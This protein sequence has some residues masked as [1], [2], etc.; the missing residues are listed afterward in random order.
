MAGVDLRSLLT[1]LIES[2]ED[3]L[4]SLSGYMRKINH[5]ILIFATL[6]MPT[7]AWFGTDNIVSQLDCEKIDFSLVTPWV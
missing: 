6:K 1:Y 5:M 7:R 3:T 2:T 4:L